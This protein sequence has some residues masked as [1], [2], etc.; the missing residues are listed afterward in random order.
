MARPPAPPGL[1]AAMDGVAQWWFLV[2]DHGT[3]FIF[4]GLPTFHT[5]RLFTS[6]SASKRGH[7]IGHIPV[8]AYRNSRGIYPGAEMAQIPAWRAH[9][10]CTKAASPLHPMNRGSVRIYELH[11]QKTIFPRDFLI[12]NDKAQIYPINKP[13][14]PQ[15]GHNTAARQLHGAWH[16]SRHGSRCCAQH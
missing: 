15:H 7:S 5:N 10:T 13:Y 3:L 9:G 6:S 4:H 8:L 2:L 1:A 14:S 12:S 16:G 11:I